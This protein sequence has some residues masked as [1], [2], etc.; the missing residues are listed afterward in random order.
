M[1]NTNVASN[2]G[3][4]RGCTSLGASISMATEAMIFV[5]SHNMKL[6]APLTGDTLLSRL[7]M[8]RAIKAPGRATIAAPYN[9]D[10]A[11]SC[12]PVNSIANNAVTTPTATCAPTTR[13]GDSGGCLARRAD[14]CSLVS[15]LKAALPGAAASS[16]SS[17]QVRMVSFRLAVR[18]PSG[19]VLS[20]EV[21]KALRLYEETRSPPQPRRQR[22]PQCLGNA[23]AQGA[24][25]HNAGLG[26]TCS[27]PSSPSRP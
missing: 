3:Q 24:S 13:H 9:A 16:S 18:P 4:I 22:A 21:S 17:S 7:V 2:A 26:G 19:P 8:P 10:H 1:H 20:G 14:A 5:D 12:L 15:G 11:N 25:P 23:P 6:T 27:G